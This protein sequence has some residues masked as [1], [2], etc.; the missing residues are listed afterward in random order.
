[1]TAYRFRLATV[2]RL[3]RRDEEAA[4]ERLLHAQRAVADTEA[5]LDLAR[6][7]A[8]RL[9]D[10]PVRGTATSLRRQRHLCG[11]ALQAVA[12]VEAELAMRRT[13]AA[14]LRAE[15]TAAAVRVR[16]LE[17][18]DERR[19]EEHAAEQRRLQQRDDDEVASLLAARG[20]AS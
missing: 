6:A 8:R 20:R 4:R 12:A 9:A 15:W 3:R 1:V 18:L 11:A 19:R 16:G 17:R 5:R 10:A 2:L 14:A 13:E 7:E